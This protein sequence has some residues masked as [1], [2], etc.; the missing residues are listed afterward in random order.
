MFATNLNLTNLEAL[1][2]AGV[3]SGHLPPVI[4]VQPVTLAVKLIAGGNAVLSATGYGAA[5]CVGNWQFNNGSAWVNLAD[6]GQHYFGSL[7]V[8]AGVS[9][10][11]QA[12]TLLISNYTASLAGS[13]R[14]MLTNAAGSAASSVV[15]ISTAAGFAAGSFGSVATAPG[16][17]MV[18][19]WPLNDTGDPSTGTVIAYDV[20][21]GYNGV[22]LTNAQDGTANSLVAGLSGGQYVYP[23]YGPGSVMTG[24][25]GLTSSLGDWQNTPAMSNS[26]VIV[27][28]APVFPASATNVTMIAWIYPNIVEGSQTGIIANNSPGGIAASMSYGNTGYGPSQG[29]GWQW[30]NWASTYNY[31]SGLVMPVGS[32]SMVAMCVSP[33]NAVFYVGN[34]NEGLITATT[35]LTNASGVPTNVVQQWGTNVY[36]GTDPYSIPA[37]NFGGYISSV[38]FFTNTLTVGQM[39]SLYNAGV[40]G[41]ANNTYPPV[42]TAQPFAAYHLLA[43]GS[44]TIKASGYGG[45]NGA[46]FWQKW[47]GSA[48]VNVTNGGDYANVT[49]TTVGTLQVGALTLTNVTAA[50]AASYQLVITNVGSGLSVASSPTVVTL[51]S[52]PP[53]NSFEAVAL[54][55]GYGLTAFWPLNETT[56]I[57]PG[58]P[59]VEAFDIWG[60]WNGY[61]G[62]NAG[63]GGYNQYSGTQY[64]SPVSGPMP[65]SVP[66]FPGGVVD[67]GF[68]ANNT[69]LGT[70][71]N[72]PAAYVTTLGSPTFAPNTTNYTIAAWIEPEYVAVE[73]QYVGL[74]VLNSGGQYDGLTFASSDYLGYIVDNNRSPNTSALSP[75]SNQ[76][77]FVALVVSNT[78]A[79]LYMGNTNGFY[80][81]AFTLTTNIYQP[82][83]TALAIGGDPANNPIYTFNGSISSVA[84]FSNSLSPAQLG[85]LYAAGLASGFL[86]PIIS[87]EPYNTDV[88]T[89]RPAT[90]SIVA[91]GIG[92]VT[93]QWQ[94][95]NP[96]N[97]TW[98]NI[99]NGPGY[100]GATNATL[101]ISNAS[102]ANVGSY[103]VI[104]TDVSGSVTNLAPVTLAVNSTP[105]NAYSTA[106]TALNPIGYWRLFDPPGSPYA[107]DYWGGLTG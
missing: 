54:T 28:N 97:S 100:S 101:V 12:G 93:Y 10:I 6:D 90:F 104:V 17:G 30:N 35:W 27:S 34:T 20:Y 103:Q 7:A 68:P 105:L 60:G 41:S 69:A 87:T 102:A 14:L 66:G 52:N 53:A 13:Y 84:I 96:R 24:F 79:T 99:V 59:Q 11:Y 63:N 61:Y 86:P 77:S 40:V 107:F 32:W 48:W 85:Y 64:G 43:G 36:I 9:G 88:Y 82:W 95:W 22:Y 55:P 29:S 76:W 39:Q 21:G 42:I 46:G 73:A 70:A 26:Y 47:N 5:P 62:T 89:G 50:D 72:T 8:P 81:S 67:S 98:T 80:S 4:T 45:L 18:S 51:L 91:N 16:T 19:Y 2:S 44:A 1:Y 65:T 3:A 49:T 106:V 74:V 25:S 15:V 57:V 94:E 31:N 92:N 23:A 33:S 75:P 38:A 37:R 71:S 78:S 58:N 56:S 83:G